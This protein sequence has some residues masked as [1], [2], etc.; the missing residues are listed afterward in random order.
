M[1]S[2]IWLIAIF[3]SMVFQ[4]STGFTSSLIQTRSSFVSS[5]NELELGITPPLGLFDPLGFLEREPEKFERRRAVERKHGRIAMIAVVGNIV[6][7]KLIVFDGYLSLSNNLKFRQIPEGF[8]G[9][10][11][12]PVEGIAQILFFIALI[13]LG[14]LPASRYDG[15]YGL[16]YFGNDILDPE[17]KIRKLN[18]ELN[19]GRLAMIGITGSFVQEVVTGQSMYAQ[20]ATGHLSPFG[21][22]K[23]FF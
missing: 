15:D 21:D 14:W 22:G 5:I 12:V 8:S 16:G 2:F 18:I 11:A 3:L 19:N 17:L 6:H 7:N 10:A 9:M 23:G 20:Y 1:I 13:E 4:T